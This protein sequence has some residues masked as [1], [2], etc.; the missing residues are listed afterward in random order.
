VGNRIFLQNI[1]TE[2]DGT[3]RFPV[4]SPGPWMVSAVKMIPSE[5]EGADYMSHWASLVFEVPAGVK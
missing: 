1:Y 3:I 5:R 4:S 2:K